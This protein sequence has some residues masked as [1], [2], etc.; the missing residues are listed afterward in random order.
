[1]NLGGLLAKKK[2][3][4]KTH[5]KLPDDPV[6]I[7]L[8]NQ[9]AGKHGHEVAKVLSGEELTDDEVA[10]R[11]GIRINLVRRIL[12]EL[13]ENRLANYRRVRDEN[14]GWY[15]YYWQLDPARALEYVNANQRQ[16]LQKLEEQLELEKNTMYFSCSNEDPKM[17]FEQ[18][19]ENDFK[20]PKCGGKLESY[21]NSNVITS[22]EQRIQSLRQ[23]ILGN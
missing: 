21:D 19:A 15:V 22:L 10:N 6:V 9:I 1:M 12:Y 23:Q 16:L 3:P 7:K 14:S 5:P 2:A 18:A 8:L 17:P 4:E 13:Y 11:T 20:C